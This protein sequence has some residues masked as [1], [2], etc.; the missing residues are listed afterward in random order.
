MTVAIRAKAPMSYKLC[1]Q[2]FIKYNL[3]KLVTI[4]L[5][6]SHFLCFKNALCQVISLL[7]LDF[8]IIKIQ[9]VSRRLRTY[10]FASFPDLFIMIGN[11]ISC[12]E[13]PRKFSRS[14]RRH[15]FLHYLEFRKSIYKYNNVFW[16]KKYIFQKLGINCKTIF[17]KYDKR[18]FFLYS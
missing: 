2:S 14:P 15:F 7:H 6:P 11:E 16:K 10:S 1:D 17:A 9:V 13:K 12:A 8:R 4:H 3:Y 18:Q 5:F